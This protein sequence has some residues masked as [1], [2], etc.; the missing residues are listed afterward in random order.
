LVICLHGA[1]KERQ[2]TILIPVLV[3]RRQGLLL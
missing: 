2:D 1:V 3:Q